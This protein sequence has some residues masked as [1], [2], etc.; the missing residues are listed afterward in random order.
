MPRLQAANTARISAMC[1]TSSQPVSHECPNWMVIYKHLIRVQYILEKTM[2]GAVAMP[3]W[4]RFFV[5]AIL[6]LM[7]CMAL[8]IGTMA[9]AGTYQDLAMQQ[10][11][12]SL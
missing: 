9:H 3:W 11:G 1:H 10:A 7:L 6:V 8:A 2:S 12:A 5:A 4:K